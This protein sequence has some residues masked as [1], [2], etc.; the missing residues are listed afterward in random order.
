MFSNR[1]VG[2]CYNNQCDEFMKG[3]F[4]LNYGT[5]FYCPGCRQNGEIAGEQRLDYPTD[6]GLYT[7]VEIHYN[8]Q[9]DR[10]EYVE[11]AIVQ[12]NGMPTFGVFIMK[13]PLI[14]T[15][16]R[17]LKVA[18][19]ILCA[20]NAGRDKNN[21]TQEVTYTMDCSLADFKTQMKSLEKYVDEQDRRLQSYES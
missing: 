13:S 5:M 11:R 1:G 21:L 3:V 18:E 4:L 14:K 10:R 17:A 19:T 7:K 2:Y 12:I 16:R 9:P 6:E 20:L 8:Y 15:E